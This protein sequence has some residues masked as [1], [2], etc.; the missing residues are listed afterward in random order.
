MQRML[1]WITIIG[2][3]L[4]VAIVAALL[5]IPRFVDIKKYK[6]QIEQRIADATGR[7]FSVGDDLSLSLIPWAGLSFSDLKLGSLP[8][9]DEKNFVTVTSFEVRV[10]LLPLLF[11]DIQVKRFLLKGARIVLE[12][13]KDGR[14]S[15]DFAKKSPGEIKL[16]TPPAKPQPS[17]DKSKEGRP[18]DKSK[19][20]AGDPD[21]GFALKSLVVGDFAVTKGS[22]LWIDHVKNRRNEISDV[23]LKLQD[24]SLERPF[25]LLF[26]ARLDDKPL[27]LQGSLGPLGKD[28]GKGS[29]PFDL[30]FKAL[31]QFKTSLKG[32]IVDPAAKPRFDLDVQVAPF[33]PRKLLAALGQPFPVKTSDPKALNSVAFKARLEGDP[34]HI[35]VS[36]GVMD[37]DASKLKLS[38]GVK[39]F[40]KPDV[41]FD[42]DLDKVDLDQYLPPP[43]AEETSKSDQK[44]KSTKSDSKAKSAEGDSKAK[45][46]RDDPKTEAAGSRHKDK[47]VAPDKKKVDYAP[48]RRLVLNGAVKIGELKIKNAGI[49][50]VRLKIIGKNGIFNLAP[51]SMSLYQGKVAGNASLN[52]KKNTPKTKFNIDAKGIQA[53]PLLNDV[54]K[55]DLLEGTLTARVNMTLSGDAPETIKKTVS[56]DGDLLFLDGAVKGIDLAGM[57]RNI[58][59]VFGQ[60]EQGT[61]KP[62]T[63]FAELHVPFTIKSG[64]TKTSGTKLLSPLL[65]VSAVGQADLVTEV[66]DFRV[67]PKFVGT[68]KGQGDT[69]ERSG[70]MVP[71]LISGSFSSPKFR[72]DLEG[73]LKQKLE[74]ELPKLQERLLG[75]DK[76]K[77]E[78]KSLEKQLKGFFKSLPFGQ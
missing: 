76:Q 14:V 56:G 13:G 73:L 25:Q 18:P 51:F 30:V 47:A 10:K 57:V 23:N 4:I 27:S 49:Q 35:S 36:D 58:K 19:P 9:F 29:V 60:A 42:V 74:K 50:D 8:G 1:K 33:S 69:K 55:K 52:V 15:W 3:C 68:L 32:Q 45:S 48:L 31:E 11:K 46:V 6:P 28:P 26:I 78:S 53:G 66:L 71:V 5:L 34:Q 22:V 61:A 54:L 40:S 17:A 59:A 72:P 70:I 77:G 16:K 62:K 37:I 67:E 39:E 21:K 20:P 44:A 65:R 24:V 41:T 64:V 38:A 2:G 75:G 43:G 63:D 12:K 7:A